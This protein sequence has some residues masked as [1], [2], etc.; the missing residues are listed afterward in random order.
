MRKAL[1]GC[2]ALVALLASGCSTYSA[3]VPSVNGKSYV[4]ATKFLD[5]MMY[6]CDANDGKPVCTEPAED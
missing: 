5:Q 2:M 1:L 6:H 3:A 4:A